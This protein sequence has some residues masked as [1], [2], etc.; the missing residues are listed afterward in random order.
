MEKKHTQ[1]RELPFEEP[2]SAE[3]PKS[4]RI[5]RL[6]QVQQVT[7]LGRSCIYQM[8]ALNQFPQRIKIGVRAVG[9]I[10]SEVQQWLARRIAQSRAANGN[11]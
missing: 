5:L 11:S 9:W 6:D 10:E 3:Q 4:Q 7:G 8:Q 1:Q 2:E